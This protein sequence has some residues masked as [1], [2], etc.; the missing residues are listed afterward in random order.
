MWQSQSPVLLVVGST[1][2]KFGMRW[3]ARRGNLNPCA[4]IRIGMSYRIAHF[5]IIFKIDYIYN[6]LVYS[7]PE[8]P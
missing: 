3:L 7:K 4:N 8:N 5:Y 2:E 6:F 1:I